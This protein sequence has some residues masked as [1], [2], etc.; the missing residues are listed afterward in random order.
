MQHQNNQG[1]VSEIAAH[2]HRCLKEACDQHDPDYYP[3]F[4][5]W[6][7]EYFQIK[8]RGEARGVGGLFFD[9][10][11]RDPARDFAFVRDVGD[12]F[13]EAY[14]PIVQRRKGES[15]SDREAF[16]GSMRASAEHASSLESAI[17]GT[18]WPAAT[19]AWDALQNSCTACHGVYRNPEGSSP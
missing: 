3:R 15:W 5:R 6:C 17:A 4:K 7:D 1:V 12:R 13:V 2:F 8:H 16:I 10:L 18:D 11:D 14:L 9:Y 19:T